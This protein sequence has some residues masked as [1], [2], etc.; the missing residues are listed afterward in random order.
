[1]KVPWFRAIC[2]QSKQSLNLYENWLGKYGESQLPVSSSSYYVVYGGFKGLWRSER[3]P[4]WE[5]STGV[6]RINFPFSHRLERCPRADNRNPRVREAKK[7]FCM[8]FT[9]SPKANSGFVYPILSL[10]S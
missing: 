4:E 1:M 3:P 9:W 8:T 10:V 5:V 7:D 2:I 6:N